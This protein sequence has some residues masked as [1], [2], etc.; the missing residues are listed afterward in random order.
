[1]SNTEWYYNVTSAWWMDKMYPIIQRAKVR[2]YFIMFRSSF[3]PFHKFYKSNYFLLLPKIKRAEFLYAFISS[4]EGTHR[5]YCVR[6]PMRKVGKATQIPSLRGAWLSRPVA[7]SD[8]II[9]NWICISTDYV[10]LLTL[11]VSLIFCTWYI[12]GSPASD[13]VLFIQESGRSR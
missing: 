2:V 11:F 8:P 9:F 13:K 5:L 12:V 4:L 6:A 7:F 3:H 10:Y 1:M